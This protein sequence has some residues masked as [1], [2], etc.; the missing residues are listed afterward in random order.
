[1]IPELLEVLLVT[2]FHTRQQWCRCF[3]LVFCTISDASLRAEG[4]NKER[5][6][7]NVSS[8]LAVLVVFWAGV[9]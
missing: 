6:K 2:H 9:Q 1:M 4:G 3:V 5:R 7:E 8:L